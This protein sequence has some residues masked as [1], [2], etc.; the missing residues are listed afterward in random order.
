MCSQIPK[1]IAVVVLAGAG[2]AADLDGPT[3]SL[4]Q[5]AITPAIVCSQQA[6]TMLDIRGKNFSP[7]PA[8]V[9]DKPRLLL[10]TFTLERR[11]LLDGS[12][13]SRVK[14]TYSGDPEASDNAK[15][16]HW[17]SETH[18]QATLERGRLQAG[19]YD[20][21]VVNPNAEEATAEAAL[22]VV[23]K[24]SF[25]TQA[26]L[27]VCDSRAEQEITIEGSNFLKT[28]DGLP[29]L[30]VDGQ[31]GALSVG[32]LSECTALDVG[33][34]CS[35]AL[36]TSTGQLAVGTY[37]A[38]LV[39]PEPA[40]C[41]TDETLRIRVIAGPQLE[42]DPVDS[43]CLRGQ[44]RVLVVRGKGFQDVDGA[45]PSATLAGKAATVVAL[46]DCDP[47]VGAMRSCKKLQIELPLGNLAPSEGATTLVVTNPAPT[48]CS[49]SASVQLRDLLQRDGSGD[50]TCSTR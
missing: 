38:K 40:A 30:Q 43:V 11:A 36:L 32:E 35:R 29:T 21:R 19:V 39:N 48:S 1:T 17:L 22:T 4:A 42:S 18:M 10:P 3:P 7:V 23:D 31:S 28:K 37:E 47:D 14:L 8:N 24:P 20:A 33:A 46:D 45:W 34:L 26:E 5:V 16:L 25:A 50:K 49:A 13:G 9:P 6:S 2:C 27:L 41:Q 15:A 44:T 12:K